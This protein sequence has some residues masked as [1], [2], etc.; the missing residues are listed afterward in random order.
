[1][2]KLLVLLGIGILLFYIS[3]VFFKM[4]DCGDTAFSHPSIPPD[5]PCWFPAPEQS[6]GTAQRSCSAFRFQSW[7]SRSGRCR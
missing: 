1:M 6:A 2:K 4:I 5:S 7:S 3:P